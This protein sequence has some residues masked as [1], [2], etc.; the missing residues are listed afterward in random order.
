MKPAKNSIVG[1]ADVDPKSIELNEGNWRTHPK[2]QKE[3]VKDALGK[4][5]WVQRV[6]VNKNTNR[7]VD[8]HLRVAIAR[9]RK[10]ATIPVSYVDLTP[11]QESLALATFDPIGALAFA[12]KAALKDLIGSLGEQG[13]AIGE[14]LTA[15]ATAAGLSMGGGTEPDAKE[16]KV[17]RAQPVVEAFVVV[18]EDDSRCCAATRAQIKW[19]TETRRTNQCMHKLGLYM[20]KR[21]THEESL[22]VEAERYAIRCTQVGAQELTLAA[23]IAARGAVPILMPTEFP[24][25]AVPKD[26]IIGYDLDARSYPL[27]ALSERQVALVGGDLSLLLSTQK[28][29]DNV[30]AVIATSISATSAKGH[31]ILWQERAAAGGLTPP[32]PLGKTTPTVEDLGFTVPNPMPIAFNVNV[33]TFAFLLGKIAQDQPET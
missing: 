16:P 5:G 26:L 4:I 30:V 14:L 3:A 29:S 33:G 31:L 15:T 2:E 1:S 27:A 24:S 17:P 20:P 32:A 18:N 6:I 7:V 9:E 10:E 21:L 8:G 11:E 28:Q 12:D 13:D 25:A 22:A 19:A 23:D